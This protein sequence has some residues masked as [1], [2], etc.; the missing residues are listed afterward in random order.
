[1]TN[2]GNPYAPLDSVVETVEEVV[3]EPTSIIPEDIT[4]VKDIL[5]W[6]GDDSDKAELVKLEEEEK[7]N[8]RKSLLKGL[9]E[10]LNG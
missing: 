1:M 10:V 3:E 6:V 9:D 2:S 4:T 7:E 8:P 5:E